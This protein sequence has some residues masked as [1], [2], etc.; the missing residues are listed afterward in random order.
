MWSERPH[1]NGGGCPLCFEINHSRLPEDVPVRMTH[2][3]VM[4]FCALPTNDNAAKLLFVTQA[5]EIGND[6]PNLIVALLHEVF[7]YLEPHGDENDRVRDAMLNVNHLDD[8][9]PNSSEGLSAHRESKRLASMLR[10]AMI[11]ILQGRLGLMAPGQHHRDNLIPVRRQSAQRP[12]R[13]MRKSTAPKNCKQ[14]SRDGRQH[15]SA[16][17]LE[18]RRMVQTSIQ[19]Q[20]PRTNPFPL[21]FTEPLKLDDFDSMLEMSRRISLNRQSGPAR[22]HFDG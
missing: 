22:Q 2:D 5:L 4:T 15:R 16:A 17:R 9:P 6:R 7:T 8:A 10:A 19:R 20:N 3:A 1:L 21:C 18:Q 13:V 12:S 11:K 14:P